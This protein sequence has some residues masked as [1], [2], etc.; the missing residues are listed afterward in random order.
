MGKSRDK[1]TVGE[2]NQEKTKRNIKQGD[3]YKNSV[4]KQISSQ[5]L[6]T[7]GTDFQVLHGLNR[8]PYCINLGR[9]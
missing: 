5:I 6:Q 7:D 4:K 2:S 9:I 8:Y 1:D 3:E